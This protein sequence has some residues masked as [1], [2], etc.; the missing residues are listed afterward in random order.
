MNRRALLAATAALAI[1]GPRSARAGD[2]PRAPI[3]DADPKILADLRALFDKAG[4]SLGR[5]LKARNFLLF[6]ADARGQG[7]NVAPFCEELLASA[8]DVFSQA[9]LS[10]RAPDQRLTVV[11]LE[12]DRYD[13]F[14]RVSD[15]PLGSAGHYSHEYRA[16][17]LRIDHEY[18]DLLAPADRDGTFVNLGHEC[19]HQIAY[20]TGLLNAEAWNPACIVEGLATLGEVHS[21]SYPRLLRQTRRD[22]LE[23][24]PDLESRGFIPLADFFASDDFLYGAG[25]D[26]D[27]S[28]DAYAWAWLLVYVLLTERDLRPKFVAYLRAISQRKD[29]AKRVDDASEHLGDLRALQARMVRRMRRMIAQPPSKYTSF[30]RGN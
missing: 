11:V 2:P 16:S 6:D 30:R 15:G 23:R 27:S 20:R 7:I 4:M 9:W 22:R 1:P 13:L 25:L 10:P 28:L 14:N 18:G 24:L 3:R 26:L 21:W 12:P 17:F 19:M 29:K 5:G 8:M